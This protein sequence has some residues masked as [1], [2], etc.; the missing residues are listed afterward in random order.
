MKNPYVEELREFPVSARK[1][2]PRRLAVLRQKPLELLR[3]L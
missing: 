2:H 1:K 3:A